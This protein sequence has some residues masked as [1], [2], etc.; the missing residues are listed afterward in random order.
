ML[1][2]ARADLRA[3]GGNVRS[4]DVVDLGRAKTLGLIGE[5]G[6]EKELA[7]RRSAF[8]A[9]PSGGFFEPRGASIGGFLICGAPRCNRRVPA[10][11]G[12]AAITRR[13]SRGP[14]SHRI[15]SP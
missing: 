6:A 2:K 10:S 7:R 3:Q 12:F 15:F 11:E 1:R 13:P 9:R 14:I 8:A 4:M 5:A